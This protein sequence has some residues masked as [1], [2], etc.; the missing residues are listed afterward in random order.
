MTALRLSRREVMKAGVV[1]GAGLWLAPAL[2]ACSD[3]DESR[4]VFLNWQDYIDPTILDDFTDA[5]GLSVT[6]ETYASNDELA[7][8]L[9]LARAARRRGREGNTFDL[10]VPSENLLTQLRSIDGLQ[11][12]DPDIVT[13]LDN[14]AEEFR[15]EPFDPGNRFS[16]PWATGTT[17][18]GYDTTALDAPPDWTVFHDPAFEGRMTIL[19]ETRDAFAAALFALGED[20]NTRDPAT[21][22]AA[23]D[24][25]IEARSVI[26]GFDSATYLDLLAGGEL[27]VAEAYSSDV[28]IAKQRNPNLE[29]VI[30]AQGGLR[31]IDSLCIPVEAANPEGANRF[32]E[33][34]LQPQVSATNAVASQVDTGNEAAAEFVPAEIFENPAIFPPPETLAV[35]QFTEDLGEDNALYTDAWERVKAD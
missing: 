29:F 17:G 30:P 9:A 4:L 20:P 23:A 14:L 5:S 21:I 8:R 24:F 35:L 16:V 12:L 18:I 25:L 10:I 11:E 7:D 3:P 22:D 26:R 15:Q 13:S 19:N 28:Q 31:W 33:F 32:I 34:Y 1:A 2:A 27:V 6:Y